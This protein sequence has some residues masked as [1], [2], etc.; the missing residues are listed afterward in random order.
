MHL[1]PGQCGQQKAYECQ[2]E[3][4]SLHLCELFAK[5]EYA[6]GRSGYRQ[7]HGEDARLGGWDGFESRHP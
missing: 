1:G 5:A 6:D 2:Y 3:G 7:H 4:D